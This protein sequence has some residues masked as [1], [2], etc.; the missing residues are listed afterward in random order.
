M[1][2]GEVKRSRGR[3]ELGIKSHPVQSK[4]RLGL[5]PKTHSALGLLRL[6]LGPI[7][8]VGEY[9]VPLGIRLGLGPE[10]ILL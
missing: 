1:E 5:G 6:G 10:L 4:L 3:L 8:G 2:G 9:S 7:P